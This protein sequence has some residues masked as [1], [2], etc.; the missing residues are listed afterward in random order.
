MCRRLAGDHEDVRP[1][2]VVLGKALSGG[3]LPVRE[4][5]VNCWY[6]LSSSLKVSCVLADDN[7]MLTIKPGEV[8]SRELVKGFLRA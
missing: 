8:W 3:M 4:N 6:Y 5:I 2:I 7:I 1:D